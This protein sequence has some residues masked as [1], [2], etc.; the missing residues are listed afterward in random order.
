MS[1]KSHI[2]S[3]PVI[4]PEHS[5]RSLLPGNLT[6]PESW[7]WTGDALP[8]RL[9]GDWS[10]LLV[11]DWLTTRSLLKTFLGGSFARDQVITLGR[12]LTSCSPSSMSLM[13]VTL[14]IVER[15]SLMLT[16]QISDTWDMISSS[17][18]L[19]K[20]YLS[21]AFLAKA[22]TLRGLSLIL[23]SFS[24]SRSCCCCNCCFIWAAKTGY[25]FGFGFG[26]RVSE[27]TSLTVPIFGDAEYLLSCLQ[28]PHFQV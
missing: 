8:I 4:P 27:R 9:A 12:C 16:L 5:P 2:L 17:L 3:H 24:C 21:W 18:L 15:L 13:S 11:G 6:R 25:G 26:L 20:F 7:I 22:S 19:L 23:A 10:D 28:F 1:P 14:V